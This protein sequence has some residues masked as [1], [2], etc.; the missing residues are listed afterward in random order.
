MQKSSFTKLF[1]KCHLRN[2]N[3]FCSCP[4]ALYPMVWL[5]GRWCVL[6]I[7]GKKWSYQNNFYM[8]QSYPSWYFTRLSMYHVLIWYM[9]HNTTTTKEVSWCSTQHK[10][11]TPISL[12]IHNV[13][14]WIWGFFM[15]IES[16]GAESFLLTWILSAAGVH[17]TYSLVPSTAVTEVTVGAFETTIKRKRN[18]SSNL[19]KKICNLKSKS[20]LHSLD[21]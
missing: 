12:R 16:V 4:Y 8:I 6:S 1:W 20:W 19:C 18:Y 13:I 11:K 2:V 3:H 15:F 14:P 10:R 21:T 17:S 9:T 5:L 7:T